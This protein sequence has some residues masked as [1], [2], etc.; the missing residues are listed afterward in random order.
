MKNVLI[1]LTVGYVVGAKTA[2]KEFEQL[3]QSLAAL[4]GTDEFGEVVASAR[5]QVGGTLRELASM[6]E[7]RTA[8][9]GASHDIVERVRGLVAHD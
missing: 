7:G 1:A 5:A 3:N 4:F 2:G 6:A 8:S 9:F